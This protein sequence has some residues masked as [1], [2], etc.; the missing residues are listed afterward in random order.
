LYDLI[1]KPYVGF[2]YQEEEGEFSLKEIGICRQVLTN[3]QWVPV[4]YCVQSMSKGFIE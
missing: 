3:S 4:E 1:G 2:C